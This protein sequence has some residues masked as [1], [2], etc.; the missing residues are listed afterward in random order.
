MNVTRTK[1]VL[2]SL[3]TLCWAQMASA[4]YDPTVQRWINRDPLNEIGF[5]GLKVDRR[6]LDQEEEQ[7]LYAFLGNR[8]PNFIDEYGLLRITGA[9]W[10]VILPAVGHC[11]VNCACVRF[12][13]TTVTRSARMEYYACAFHLCITR[14]LPY[15]VPLLE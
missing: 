3:L 6:G 4:Y 5:N 2:I 8:T 15:S 1:T 9:C 10:C 14:G 12:D 11:V 13:L 7:N